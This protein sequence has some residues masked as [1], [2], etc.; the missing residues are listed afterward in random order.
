MLD[1]I[2]FVKALHISKTNS[3]LL[4][5]SGVR[6]VSNRGRSKGNKI[7]VDME[8]LGVEYGVN[9]QNGICL[10]Y[11][12]YQFNKDYALQNNVYFQCAQKTRKK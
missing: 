3:N 11:K 7:F 10:M 6:H 9:H 1:I 12:G 4:T 5:L 8:A 2:N